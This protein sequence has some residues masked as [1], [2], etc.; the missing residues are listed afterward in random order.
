MSAKDEIV[1]MTAA[2]LG[3]IEYRCQHGRGDPPMDCI[4]PDCLCGSTYPATFAFHYIQHL[5]PFR[6]PWVRKS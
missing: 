6:Y 2:D 3:L 5:V 1:E 4:Y